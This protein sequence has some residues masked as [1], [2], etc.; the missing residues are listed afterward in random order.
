MAVTIPDKTNVVK[1]P[2]KSP[3]KLQTSFNIQDEDVGSRERTEHTLEQKSSIDRYIDVQTQQSE[4]SK[5]SK[6][7]KENPST[8]SKKLI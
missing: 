1:M 4:R 6:I 8:R 5:H 3:M 7:S 2:P